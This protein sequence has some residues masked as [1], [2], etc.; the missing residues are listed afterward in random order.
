MFNQGLS[1][2]S[3][4]VQCTNLQ[5]DQWWIPTKFF[6]IFQAFHWKIPKRF[7]K[8][9]IPGLFTSVLICNKHRR[10]Q[11]NMH[12]QGLSVMSPQ[13]PPSWS[14]YYHFYHSLIPLP[15]LRLVLPPFC[16]CFCGMYKRYLYAI[17]AVLHKY[18]PFWQCAIII[19]RNML[20]SSLWVFVPCPICLRCHPIPH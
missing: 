3:S 15:F 14:S 8:M 7:A 1:S 4:L 10:R 9:S 13:P 19:R 2:S 11:Y 5:W 17:F 18:A 6:L 12:K 16:G 20:L